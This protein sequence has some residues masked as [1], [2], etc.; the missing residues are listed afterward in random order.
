VTVLIV[1]VWK[2]VKTVMLFEAISNLQ[3]G[4]G[5]KEYRKVQRRL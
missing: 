5:K 1:K 3:V 4:Y 2:K